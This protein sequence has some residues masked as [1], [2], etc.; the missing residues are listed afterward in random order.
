[1]RISDWSSDVCSSD[2]CEFE[3]V[4][5]VPLGYTYHDMAGFPLEQGYRVYVS[6]WHPIVRYGIRHDWRRLVPYPC[7]LSDPS[8]WGNLLAFRDPI[9]ESV[10]AG[11]IGKLA[12]VVEMPTG[13][14][15][16]S[17]VLANDRRYRLVV[18]PAFKRISARK[19]VV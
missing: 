17:L 1:M 6:E 13:Q 16:N 14:D 10:L 2:L 12:K 9:D 4:K 3:D 15:R 8:A 5:T 19:S 18:D 11:A 7:E